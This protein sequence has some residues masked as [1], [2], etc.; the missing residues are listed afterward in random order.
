V[1]RSGPSHWLALPE[2]VCDYA[3]AW[4]ALATYRWGAVPVCVRIGGTEWGPLCCSAPAVRAVVKKGVREEERFG[5]G[6]TVSV[7]M[8]EAPPRCSCRERYR[9]AM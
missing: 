9:P 7:A 8:S 3:R 6:D 4:A 2:D 1:A 5:D